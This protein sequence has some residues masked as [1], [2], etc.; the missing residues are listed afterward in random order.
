MRRKQVCSLKLVVGESSARGFSLS[1]SCRRAIFRVGAAPECNWRV[2]AE[3][4]ADHHFMMMWNGVV[5]SV[6]DVGARDLLVNGK[7]ISLST[8]LVSG[9]IEFGSA[10]IVV[11]Q[12]WQGWTETPLPCAI[13]EVVPNQ[14]EEDRPTEPRQ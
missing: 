2:S 1:A 6:I 9:R 8:V 13:R 4:V 10:A 14:R 12:H 11:E 5:L 7:E 3:G